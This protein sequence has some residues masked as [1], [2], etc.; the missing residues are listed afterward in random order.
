[1]AADPGAPAD[2]SMM[3][4]VHSALRRD[5][6]RADAVLTA[7]PAPNERQRIALARHI[8]WMMEFLEAHHRSE[9]HGLYPV[10]RERAADA[11]S[12]LDD[13]SADHA[14]VADV[15]ATVEA[16]AAAYA[17][18]D[19]PQPLALAIERLSEVLLPHLRREEDELMPI[20]SRVVTTAEWDAI[21]QANNIVDKSKAQLAM[22]G[23]WLIDGA[24]PSDRARV[25]GLV[26]LVPRLVLRYGF[27]PVYRRRQRVCWTSDRGGVQHDGATAVVTD[28]SFEAVWDIIRDPT[29]VGEWSHECVGAEWLGDATEARPGARF[30]G[31]NRQGMFRWGRVCEIVSSEPGTLVWRTVPT[32]LYPDST[33][34]TLRAVRVHGATRIE[35]SFHVVKG[36]WLEVV[37]ARFLPAHRERTAALTRDLERIGELAVSVQRAN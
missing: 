31:R 36:T 23:H 22:E 19:D 3:R 25:L 26:P 20:V 9:D 29:R 16:T 35:Q 6:A 32:K 37:Y 1:M 28:A 10:V 2:T 18:R 12:L 14:A 17:E 21:E 8:R 33:E 27:G 15:V 4:I 34:W 13:M 11:A 7:I 5:L 30:R 24:A